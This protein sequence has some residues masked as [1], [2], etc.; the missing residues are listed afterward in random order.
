MPSELACENETVFWSLFSKMEKLSFL[1]ILQL[2]MELRW[3]CRLVATVLQDLGVPVYGIS[4]LAV[5]EAEAGWL[6]IQKGEKLL[7]GKQQQESTFD[8][9]YSEVLLCFLL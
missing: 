3:S 8:T 2:Y 6:L 1:I 9:Y 7:G 4:S 5:E